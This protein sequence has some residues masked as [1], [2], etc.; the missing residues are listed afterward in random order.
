M[1]QRHKELGKAIS[2]RRQE[3]R[4][5]GW[6]QVKKAYHSEMPVM[7]IDKQIDAME[8]VESGEVAVAALEDD[9]IPPA[10]TFGC[11][12]HERVA[13]AFFGPTAE[14]LTGDEALSRRIQVVNDLAVLCELREPPKRGPKLDWSKYDEETDLDG[15]DTSTAESSENLKLEDASQM[16][17][18]SFPTD[19]CIFCAGDTTLRTFHPRSKQRPDSL[20]RHLENQHLSRLTEQVDCPHHVCKEQGVE[21]F[22]NREVWLNHAAVVHMYDLKVQLSRLSS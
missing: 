11:E 2:R 8:G 13:D 16:P 14:T 9:W 1:H 5:M 6:D 10:P 20:R 21:P 7:E 12:E 15:T 19:Q 22:P 17:D 3:L 4:R 18:L